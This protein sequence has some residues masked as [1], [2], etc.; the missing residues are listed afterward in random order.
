MALRVCCTS[1]LRY[2]GRD[3]DIIAQLQNNPEFCDYIVLADGS[4]KRTLDSAGHLLPFAQEIV[5]ENNRKLLEDYGKSAESESD[6]DDR[7]ATST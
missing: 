4:L 1:A 7:Q 6:E 5:D 3:K 2:G